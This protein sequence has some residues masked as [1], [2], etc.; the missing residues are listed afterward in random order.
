MAG[1]KFNNLSRHRNHHLAPVLSSPLAICLV[2]LPC[3]QPQ[4]KRPAKSSQSLKSFNQSLLSHLTHISSTSHHPTKTN[5]TQDDEN[6]RF[7]QHR[8]HSCSNQQ[9][10]CFAGSISVRATPWAI[11]SADT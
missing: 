11:S 7:Q 3:Q 6:T 4:T 8:C 10:H 9:Y 1:A 2:A 5:K